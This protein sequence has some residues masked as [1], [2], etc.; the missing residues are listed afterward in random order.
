MDQLTR[1]L[2]A[3]LNYWAEKEL[4]SGPNEKVW[5]LVQNSKTIKVY[6]AQYSVSFQEFVTESPGEAIDC[7]VG[8]VEWESKVLVLGD[9]TKQLKKGVVNV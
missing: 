5:K 7:F 2:P 8:K 4:V 3:I 9:I 1:T 6:L